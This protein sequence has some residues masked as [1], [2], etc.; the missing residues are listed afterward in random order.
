MALEIERKF[1]VLGDSWRAEVSRSS[2]LRQG[3]LSGAG[4]RASVRVRLHD[5]HA[6]LNI[7]AAVIGSARAE[8]EYPI[9]YDQGREIL[10]TLCLGRLEKI[11][12]YIERDGVTWE[13]DEFLGDNAGLIVAEV[14]LS[15]PDQDFVRPDW[16][17]REVT[18]ARRYYNHDLALQPYCGWPD[19][20]CR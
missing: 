9:P 14:E 11:R 2:E 6:N 17:G 8:Y 13:I 5:R 19:E 10:Q 18:D 15:D 16:L 20:W 3:Y 12:H 7:K 1:L 4:G